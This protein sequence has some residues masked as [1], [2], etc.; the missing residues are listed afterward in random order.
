MKA[1]K[2]DFKASGL[3]SQVEGVPSLE[4]CWAHSRHSRNMCWMDEF[5]EGRTPGGGAGL[6][7]GGDDELS[8]GDMQ[9]R[10]GYTGG[11]GRGRC[12]SYQLIQHNGSHGI[13][14]KHLQR[15]WD[16]KVQE[17]EN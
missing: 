10:G 12:Q 6:L 15:I 16:I 9:Q 14:F 11:L 13:G 1:V 3:G 5:T 17:A 2:V 4:H 8:F 7:G